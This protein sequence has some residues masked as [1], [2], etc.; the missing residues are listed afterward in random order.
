MKRTI[1][2][3]DNL[4][5]LVEDCKTELRDD[6]REWLLDNLDVDDRNDY[7]QG[8]G[9]DRMHEI[10]DSN[11]PIY[12]SDIDGLYYLY[13]D[14]FDEAYSNAGL[15]D[16]SEDNRKQIAIYCYLYEKT[17]R[18]MEELEDLI[19][20]YIDYRDELVADIEEKGD[21]IEIQNFWDKLYTKKMEEW[22]NENL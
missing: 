22:I 14:E 19:K 12:Y 3:D 9:G 4:D 5:E 7:Y 10:A 13:G 8:Q 20:E 1:E 2:I 15:G 18:Y 21:D 11:T 16:G 17:A 6:L